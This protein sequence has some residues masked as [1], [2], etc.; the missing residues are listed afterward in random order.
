MNH[1]KTK[2]GSSNEEIDLIKILN[3]LISSKKII[4]FFT[5]FFVLLTSLLS[6]RTQETYNSNLL[7]R[8]GDPFSDNQ[9]ERILLK[10]IN[11]F[12]QDLKIHFK[13]EEFEPVNFS[14]IENRLIEIT[15]K[16]LTSEKG[17]ILLNK[18]NSFI[19]ESANLE[20]SNEFNNQKNR[21]LKE[22]Q[23]L[24]EVLNFYNQLLMT[25]PEEKSSGI[26][27]EIFELSR[28]LVNLD[29]EILL[30]NEDISKFRDEFN[31]EHL[32]VTKMSTLINRSYL[33]FIGGTL[34]FLLSILL[35]LGLE[36][37]KSLKK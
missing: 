29:N 27:L 19:N 30:L 3:L 34:G 31:I 5:L 15:I 7:V 25:M 35:A 1:T 20:T 36:Y 4:I 26:K 9:F 8:I 21:R 17:D 16:N 22:K 14:I 37:F 18:I 13:Y 12:V 6:L 24:N 2:K 11:S 23:H 10:N 32:R 28:N 33:I